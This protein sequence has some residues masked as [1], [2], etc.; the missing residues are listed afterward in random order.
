MT[1]CRPGRTA[2]LVA[3][4]VLLALTVLVATPATA[5][6]EPPSR[7]VIE[8]AMTTTWP[9]A[10]ELAAPVHLLVDAATGQVLSAH[11]A[12]ER[13]PVASTVKIL[14]ALTV[15]ANTQLDDE[16]QVGDEVLA[17]GASVG[18]QPG[19]RWTIEQL[20]QGILVRSGN[21][22]AEALATAVGGDLD[23]FVELMSETARAV[24]LRVGP[25]EVHLTSPSGL[26]DDQRLSARD[27]ATLTR[28]LLA[29][30]DLR[31][32]VGAPEVQL[33]DR[34]PGENRNLLIGDY[35]GATGVKT[36]YTEA[37]GNS[38]VASARRGERE[39][40]AVVLG[41]GPDPER[42]RDAATLLDHGFD[43]FVDR[44][45]SAELVLLAAGARWNLVVPPTPVVVPAGADAQLDVPIP[46]RLPGGDPVSVPVRLDGQQVASVDAGF[47]PVT[48][49]EP[50][51]PTGEGAAIGRA[52][53]DGIYAALRAAF[54]AEDELVPAA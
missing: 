43:R 45:L 38:V 54:A 32:I 15:A 21:D 48:D 47:Q 13:R 27:L 19:E 1:S 51:P 18:L 22:A 2:S 40:I 42:F 24:G 5:Q 36:G 53:A 52:A 37:A 12:D 34:E 26:D 3:S 6:L 25:D 50:E 44:T 39:L 9:D 35:P 11:A 23:G 31:R 4:L 16:V 7:P 46:V 14:T 8:G 49:A 41:A 33:P 20:L 30:P 17:P 10:P 28:V 29:D